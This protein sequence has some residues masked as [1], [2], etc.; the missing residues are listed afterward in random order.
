MADMKSS[1]AIQSKHEQVS[2][3]LT[4]RIADG[5]YGAGGVL[6]SEAQLMQELG[7]SRVTVRRALASLVKDGLIESRQGVGYLIRARRARPLVGIIYGN[8]AFAPQDSSTYRQLIHMLPQTLA[9][10][11]LTTQLFCVRS[12]ASERQNDRDDLIAAIRKRVLHAIVVMAWP[13]PPEEDRQRAKDDRELLELIREHKVPMT[14]L[15]DMHQPGMFSLDYD[16]VGYEGTK[17][18]LD[19]GRR[20]VA[21]IAGDA[22]V[23]DQSAVVDGH[24]A[25]MGE[26]NAE[27]DL[28]WIIRTTEL[29]RA[30]GYQAMRQLLHMRSRPDAVVIGD[31]IVA[32]G[33]MTAV[34]EAGIDVPGDMALASL[35]VTGSGLFFPKPFV[36]LQVD[37]QE[38]TEAVA[39]RVASTASGTV[40]PPHLFRPRVVAVDTSMP[41]PSEAKALIANT[42]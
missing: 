38:M 29:S 25:A 26:Y 27:I 6:P 37:F 31:D 30:A 7:V 17:H 8:N 16:A 14:G 40:E 12:Y 10:N 34:L 36:Q 4:V 2:R 24:R 32:C 33:A 3:L 5:N 21:V 1:P 23:I 11:H 20:R 22:S 28:N 39:Q 19:A 42:A 35:Y 18:F 41:K 9:K 13:C 15:S